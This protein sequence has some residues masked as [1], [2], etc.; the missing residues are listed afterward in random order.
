M[1]CLGIQLYTSNHT[2][3]APVIFAVLLRSVFKDYVVHHYVVDRHWG[4]LV[5]PECLGG[6]EGDQNVANQMLG[7][8]NCASDAFRQA[9]LKC[10]DF[11][12]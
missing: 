11:I 6:V 1:F 10:F 9:F 3:S 7:I 8:S 2:A 5:N 12:R 4:S